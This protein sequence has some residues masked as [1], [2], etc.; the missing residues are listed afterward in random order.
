MKVGRFLVY[1][2]GSNQF[3]GIILIGRCLY[4]PGW[5]VAEWVLCCSDEGRSCGTMNVIEKW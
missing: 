5:V 3:N 1:I 2:N 4:G